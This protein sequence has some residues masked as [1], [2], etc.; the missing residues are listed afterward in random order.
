[1]RRN[2]KS[3]F[4]SENPVTHDEGKNHEKLREQLL[5]TP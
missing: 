2:G 5:P 3:D 4:V 1:V